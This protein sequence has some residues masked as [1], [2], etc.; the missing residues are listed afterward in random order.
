MAKIVL[1]VD[2]NVDLRRAIATFLQYYGYETLEAASGHEAIET[3]IAKRPDVVLLD[4]NLPDIEGTDAAQA[5]RKHPRTA[6]VTIIACSA[7]STAKFG[8]EVSQ[9]G[10][11]EYLQKPFSAARVLEVIEQFIH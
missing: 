3:A 5:I 6:H 11:T 1:I 2:D 4:L 10:I 9:L 8:P 7:Y